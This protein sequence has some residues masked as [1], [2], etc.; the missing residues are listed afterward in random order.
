MDDIRRRQYFDVLLEKAARVSTSESIS[1]MDR[2]EKVLRVD[3]REREANGEFNIK[4]WDHS[5]ELDLPGGGTIGIG[6]NI[7]FFDCDL[8]WLTYVVSVV[9]VIR[10]G[11]LEDQ[12]DGETSDEE[13]AQADPEE[14]DEP[15][16]EEPDAPDVVVEFEL[17]DDGPFRCDEC[18]KRKDTPQG[19]RA[20]CIAAHGREPTAKENTPLART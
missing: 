7:D 3:E 17:N 20:H 16:E 2:I 13:E 1:I 19:I 4:A 15:A 12:E 5:V 8:D 18:G 14:S 10:N 11:V 9:N 6:L